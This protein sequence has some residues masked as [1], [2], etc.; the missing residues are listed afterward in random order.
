MAL[1]SLRI[2]EGLQCET[3]VLM[4]FANGDK[5]VQIGVGTS[6]DAGIFV[7]VE[8]SGGV[9]SQR[10]ENKGDRSDLWATPDGGLV[11]TADDF[12]STG[13]LPQLVTTA[14]KPATW[15][16]IKRGEHSRR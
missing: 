7:T 6:S 16:Q 4:T 9:T 14:S 8:S 11:A 15:G 12:V 5:S 10:A 3:D 1:A 13:R 2:L